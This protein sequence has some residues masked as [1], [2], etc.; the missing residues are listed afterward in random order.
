MIRQN[1]HSNSVELWHTSYRSEREGIDADFFELVWVAWVLH[2]NDTDG[3]FPCRP[4]GTVCGPISIPN[5]GISRRTK[6]AFGVAGRLRPLR[7]LLVLRVTSTS[8][9][10]SS[11]DH[12]L[13]MA[14]HAVDNVNA[15]H[16]WARHRTMHQAFGEIVNKRSAVDMHDA[17]PSAVDPPRSQ[18]GRPFFG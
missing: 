2:C 7:T 13:A 16:L 3:P 12:M 17:K 9:E 10:L 14:R 4:T 5:R 11:R 1:G 6:F 18:N 15:H 8:S